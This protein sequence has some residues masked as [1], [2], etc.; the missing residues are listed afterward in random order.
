VAEYQFT[1]DRTLE[2]GRGT[3]RPPPRLAASSE[4]MAAVHVL[5]F[6]VTALGWEHAYIERLLHR[7]VFDQ[8]E[9]RVV[10]AW[11]KVRVVG[12]NVLSEQAP[13]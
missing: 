4:F 3:T 8:R 6:R 5:T 13:L 2:F 7:Q 10:E 12:A 1:V 9:E 11:K